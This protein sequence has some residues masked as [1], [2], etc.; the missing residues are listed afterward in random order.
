MFRRFF[1]SWIVTSSGMF[2]ISYVWHGV[3]LNDFSRLSYPKELFLIFAAV[4]YLLIGFV[5]V[6]VVEHKPTK[7]FS[8]HRPVLKGVLKGM[9][10]G[11]LFFMIATVVG[12]SFNTGTGI[13]N[14]LVDLVW[15]VLEQGTGGAIAGMMYMFAEPHL[16]SED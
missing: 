13:K 3:I 1:I 12:V 11:L 9:L 5:V 7:N 14:M 10:C 6:K 15:Q 2:L 4:T 16:F 8:I